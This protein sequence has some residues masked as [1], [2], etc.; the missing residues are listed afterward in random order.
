MSV[1]SSTHADWLAP[2]L[3][4]AR[5]YRLDVSEESVR[6][7]LAW[8]RGAPLDALI[9][10][11]A[12]QMGLGLR[13]VRFDAKLL[14]PWRLPLLVE[15]KDGQVGVIDKA[16][17]Q[18]RVSVL[19]GDERGQ[20]IDLT[21]DE[22]RGRAS[23]AAL[24][25]PESSVP[26][27]RVDGYIAPYRPSWFWRLAL[28]DWPRY[29]DIVVASL[30]A[31]VLALATMLFSMQIYDRV[32]PAQSEPTLWVLF[33]GVLVAVVFEFMLRLARTHVADVIGKRADLKISDVV[34]GRAL[35]L[36]NDARSKSTGSFIAQIRELESV[37]ELVTSTSIGAVADLPFVLMFIGVLWL[38]GG[39]LVFVALAALPLIIVPGLLAQRPLAR[40]SREGMRESALRNAMLV[41]AVEGIE[42]I[43]LLRAEP[44]FQNQWMQLNSVSADVAMQQR[45]VTG[46]LTTWTQE[47][48]S[49]V[50]AVVL[51]AGAFLVMKGEMTT[52]TLVASSILA[53]RMMAPLAQ[54]SSVFARWQQAKVARQGL[55]ELMQRPIDQPERGRL[56]HRPALQGSYELVA[57]QFRYDKDAKQPALGV[58]ALKIAA[59]ERVAVLGRMGAGKSTLLQLL[60]GLQRPQEGQLLLDG[61]DLALIDPSDVRRDMGLLTQHARLFYGSVRENLMLGLPQ[62]SDADLLRALTL[63]GA[64]PMVHTLAG[65]LDYMIHE[66]GIG[67]S[68][69]QHQALL[70][71]RTLLRQPQIVLLD[72]PTAAFDEGTE[73]QVID[74]LLPWLQ[75][76]TLVVATHRM[77]VL[78]WVDRILVVDGGRIAVDGSKAEVLAQLSKPR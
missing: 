67:L 56:L 45:F 19:L 36:R 34:F 54:L 16:D 35:R 76:R 68:G 11:M 70:L 28:R 62:A 52:G 61:V 40:L 15:F 38:I 49:L 23:R 26:D 66:G 47:L 27:A 25:R 74:G 1:V 44:R 51:L 17:G 39:P 13:L 24:L 55:D 59:G 29:G 20:A 64:L 18:G 22:M 42:D 7:A 8:E 12:R 63:A 21:V 4:V 50:Y 2:M 9:A 3:T 41:E 32:V 6:V 72:E 75:G 48:Q 33:G 71:A 5:H 65:G 78:K 46:L 31:N 69:G 60:A 37:R 14:D 30:A 57:A 53:S 10:R 73:A 43:K 77:A 58:A